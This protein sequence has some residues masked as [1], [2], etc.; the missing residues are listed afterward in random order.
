MNSFKIAN[1]AV[2]APK[3]APDAVNGTKIADRAVSFEKLAADVL[4]EH[5][6]FV[7]ADGTGANNCDDLRD[8][9]AEAGG[10]AAPAQRIVV[11]ADA[12]EFDCGSTTLEVPANVILQGFG[13]FATQTSPVAAT[14]I[15]GNLTGAV[16]SL[17]NNTVLKSLRVVNDRDGA[18]GESIG[19]ED[20][21]TL[22]IVL[23]DLEVSVE[24]G[25][26]R[27]IGIDFDEGVCFVGCAQRVLRNVTVDVATAGGTNAWG[28][29]ITSETPVLTGVQGELDNVTTEAT[30]GVANSVGVVIADD[31]SVNIK[32]SVLDGATDGV[33]ET[34]SGEAVVVFSRI[35]GQTGGVTCGYVT[36]MDGVPPAGGIAVCE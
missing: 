12:G 36:D 28:V 35:A 8:A 20:N 7:S 26:G 4:P 10:M 5:V 2:T 21:G 14:T 23:E 16:V 24:A 17:G 31:A 29:R 1:A 33:F 3:I 15:H 18:S 32:N 25:A 11:F 9:L 27:A 30:G 22:N 19:I 6:L 13:A 34:G